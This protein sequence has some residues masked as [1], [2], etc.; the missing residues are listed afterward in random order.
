MARNPL[1]PFR[2]GGGL[3]GGSDPFLSLHRDVNRL[4]DDALRGAGLPM[5]G[6]E[7]GGGMTNF[8][9]PQMNVSET[10]NEIRITAELPGVTK[11]DIDVSLDQ[12]LLTIRG[13]KRFEQTEGG[14]KENFHFVERAYGSFQR[15]IR[16]PGPLD[17]EQVQ[18]SFENGVLTITLPKAQQQE[19]SRKIQVQSGGQAG[20]ARVSARQ[21]GAE[22]SES[23]GAT[24]QHRE[25]GGE[26]QPS[27]QQGTQRRS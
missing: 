16:L 10:Q 12:D 23:R 18:A 5:A 21:S 11:Q 24:A 6:A 19:R 3:L 2:F 1:T 17:P 15:C 27:R 9:N 8:I 25:G 4:F 26:N 7:A 22:E 14:E 13:E 20:S